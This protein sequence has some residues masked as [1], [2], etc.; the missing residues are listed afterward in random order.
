MPRLQIQ[1]GR[2]PVGNKVRLI[3]IA[4]TPGLLFFLCV[5]GKILPESAAAVTLC[6]VYLS[7]TGRGSVTL[8]LLLLCASA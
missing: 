7:E 1:N 5:E 8:W 6:F 4:D 2:A 3:N